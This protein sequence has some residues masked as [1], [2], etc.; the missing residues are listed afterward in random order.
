[1]K[2][3]LKTADELNALVPD[4]LMANLGITYLSVEYGNLRASMPVNHKTCQPFGRLHGG[5]ALALAESVASAGSFALVNEYQWSVLGTEVSASHVG[6]AS[7]G[8]VI[9]EAKLLHEG[10]THHIWEVKVS[11]DSG[12]LISV[13][14]ITNTIIPAQ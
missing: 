12:K 6:S 14:R 13:C 1:M 5:A 9:A 11:T 7:K 3:I 10:K 8:M 4:T 2:K